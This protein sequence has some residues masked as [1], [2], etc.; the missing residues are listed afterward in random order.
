MTVKKLRESIEN[1]TLDQFKL[2]EYVKFFAENKE[3]MGLGAETAFKQYIRKGAEF[4]G[5]DIEDLQAVY[6]SFRSRKND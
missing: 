4:T 6:N 1:K 2:Q 5:V 3:K